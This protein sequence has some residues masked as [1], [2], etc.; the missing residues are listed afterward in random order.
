MRWS[1]WEGEESRECLASLWVCAKW[2]GSVGRDFSVLQVSLEMDYESEEEVNA[3]ADM[4][5]QQQLDEGTQRFTL[6]RDLWASA[7]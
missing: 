5:D 2:R 3:L 7:R 1:A 6:L 4:Y